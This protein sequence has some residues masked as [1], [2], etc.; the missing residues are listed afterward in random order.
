MI[1]LTYE[2]DESYENQKFCYICKKR[3]TN[4]N[5]KVRDH[6]YFTGKYREPLCILIIL[7]ISTT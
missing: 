1:S 7:I 2:E 6:C 4:N 3:F 5:I